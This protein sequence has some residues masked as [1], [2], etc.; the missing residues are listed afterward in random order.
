MDLHLVPGAE[1]TAAESAALDHVLGAARDGWD[2]GERQLG[3]EG[4]TASTGHD[5]RSRRPFH[6]R[7]CAIRNGSLN[8]ISKI[9]VS[10]RLKPRPFS[11]HNL[12]NWTGAMPSDCMN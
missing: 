1:P 7:G 5:A 9:Y 3:A 4:N 2:G 10:P 6:C 12:A 11:E 8:W